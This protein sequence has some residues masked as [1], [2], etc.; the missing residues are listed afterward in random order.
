MQKLHDLIIQNKIDGKYLDNQGEGKP[1]AN[2]NMHILGE[3]LLQLLEH[4]TQVRQ[5]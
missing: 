1:L 2:T 4:A 3:E 5:P